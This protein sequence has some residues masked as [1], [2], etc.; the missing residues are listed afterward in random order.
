LLDIQSESY[1]RFFRHAPDTY[2][3]MVTCGDVL[4]QFQRWLP[5]Y[6]DVDVLIVGLVASPE[7]AQRHG[8]MICP[9]DNPGT[10]SF[11][12]QKPTA[13]TIR[14]LAEYHA[15]YLDTGIW[16]LSKRA[17]SLLMRKC[18][19]TDSKQAFRNGNPEH[20]DLYA[21]FGPSLGSGTP[22]ADNQE[23][24]PE[25]RTLRCAVLPLADAHFYH[26]GTNRSLLA[27]VAQ[28]QRPSAKQRSFGH[29][30]M[31][32]R[33]KPIIQNSIVHCPFTSSNRHIWIDNSH[34]AAGWGFSEQ[35]V[36]TGAPSNDW[37]LQLEQGNCIDFV[38]VGNH[39][40]CI[41]FYGFDDP[42]RGPMDDPSTHWMGRRTSDWFAARGLEFGQG[43]MP[44]E[45]DIQQARI[46]PVLATADIAPAF[47]QWMLTAE[48]EKNPAFASLWANSPKLSAREL[49]SRADVA[50]IAAQR[51]L[52]LQRTL[53]SLDPTA[54]VETC[55]RLDLAA[56]ARIFAGRNWPIPPALDH[57]QTKNSSLAY[58]HDRMFQAAVSRLTE[59]NDSTQHELEAFGGLRRLIVDE[60]ALDPVTPSRTV[61]DDQ[62][63]W[64]RSPVRLDLAGGWSDTPP[65]CIEHGGRVVNVAVDL[66][67]QPPIQVFARVAKEPEIVIRSIDLGMEDRVRTYDDLLRC[68]QLGSGFSVAR[69]ALAISGLTPQFHADGGYRSLRTQLEKEFGGGLE[70]SMLAAVPKGSGLGTSSILASTLLGTLSELS[71]LYWNSND[72]FT[73]TLALEQMLTS[74]GGWQD[75]A[76]G[77]IGGLKLLET[78]PGLSQRPVIRWLPGRFFSDEYANTCS[79]LYYT[80]ITRIAHDILGEIVRKIFLNS[81]EQ[82]S[83]LE[84]IRADALYAADAIQRNDWDGLCEA[85][86]RS[87]RLN[88]C[89]DRGTN[90][91]AVQDVLDR[92]GD[93]VLAAKLLGAGGGGYMLLMAADADAGQRIKR[94]LNAAPPN[95]R[96]RF[97]DMSISEQGLQVT[98]S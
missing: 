60:T 55:S 23:I 78:E 19:W 33:T 24:D 83:I 66:N 35:N 64:G 37:Q 9:Q 62:I 32:P 41:R 10:L 86:R 75:Q 73:R 14:T 72:L 11:F 28:L 22:P 39:A 17:V 87:W 92:A 16:M 58:V 4:I 71:G 30:S 29:S 38:P 3:V 13:N 61:L 77:I 63:I 85:V 31:E 65:Y 67:G 45:T 93:D 89:L 95:A 57:D 26:L 96:A 74:G 97:V 48:P 34:I 25:V 50:E 43:G 76:G 56:T 70:I 54:W 8:V 51:T 52:G 1:K 40:L 27:S 42:F 68:D 80:G 81:A 12:L 47:I 15:Y 7:E 18:G 98:R 44:A 84:D 46:F 20:Y 79:L 21:S 2:R 94:N 36:I 90:P 5:T 49:L 91:P 82:L 69:A 88:Q 53:A 59:K 6:P